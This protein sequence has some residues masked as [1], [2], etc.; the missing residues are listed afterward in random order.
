MSTTENHLNIETLEHTVKHFISENQ[1]IVVPVKNSMYRAL[2]N[3]EGITESMKGKGGLGEHSGS[4]SNCMISNNFMVI[5]LDFLRSKEYTTFF[6]A[7]DAS[8]GFFYEIWGD[9]LPQTAAAALLLHRD[10]IL[11]DEEFDGYTYGMSMICPKDI[12]KYRELKCTCNPFSQIGKFLYIFHQHSLLT[13]K[14]I[15][16]TLATFQKYCTPRFK[17][18]LEGKL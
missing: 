3:K 4:W 11:L 1:D 15:I 12:Q 6:D 10:Q 18:A 5:S 17:Y 14:K 9:A 7:L 16:I 8:G 13:K 2:L